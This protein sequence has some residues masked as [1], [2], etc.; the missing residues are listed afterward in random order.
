MSRFTSLVSAVVFA[1]LACG[2]PD[3]GPQMDPGSDCMA[4]HASN[5]KGGD[6]AGSL[7]VAGTLYRDPHARTE[8]GLDG[9]EVVITDKNKK[10]I[11]MRTGAGGN[12]YS[13][14]SFVFP[15]QVE[16]RKNGKT[17]VMNGSPPVGSCNA[18][19]AGEAKNNAP[20][21]VFLGQ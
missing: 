10:Q 2:V 13:A 14:E 20:G 11:V 17:A 18:C 12:F 7:N 15:I 6:G 19:H 21:R 4:C 3:N 16:V 1:T 5:A 8:L 9:A